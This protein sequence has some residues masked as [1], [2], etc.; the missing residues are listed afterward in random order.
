[1]V[2]LE[3]KRISIRELERKLDKGEPVF[4]LDTRS[5][6]AWEESGVKIPGAVRL[7]YREIEAHLDEL[8]HDRTIVTYC[9]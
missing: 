2:P 7:H 3:P 6:H 1:V 5:S 9:T 4:F 8:P